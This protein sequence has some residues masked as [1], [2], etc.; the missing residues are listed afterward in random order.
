MIQRI[1]TLCLIAVVGVLGFFLRGTIATV[2]NE[3]TGDSVIVTTAYK[4][5]TKAGS[6]ETTNLWYIQ[7]LALIIIGLSVYIILQYKKRPLQL[8]LGLANSFLI[9]ALF[10][11]VAY[12]GYTSGSIVDAGPK[13]GAGF[14]LPVGAMVLNTLASRFIRRDEKLVNAADRLR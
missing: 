3:K 9:M 14:M 8:L 1:Q 6:V 10:V 5:V 2:N 12:Q 13:F 4:T 7:A 11:C